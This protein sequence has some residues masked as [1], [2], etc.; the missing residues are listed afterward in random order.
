MRQNFG[1]I[2]QLATGQPYL[3]K[4]SLLSR[5][6]VGTRRPSARSPIYVRELPGLVESGNLTRYGMMSQI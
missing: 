2:S 4:K 6:K 3:V 5:R 1:M